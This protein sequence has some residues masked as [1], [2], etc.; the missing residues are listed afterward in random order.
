M[1]IAHRDLKP[2]NILFATKDKDS[3][4]KVIDFGLSKKFRNINQKLQRMN[5]KVGTPI[6]V[7]PEIIAGEYKIYFY[8]SYSF[9]CDEWSLGCILH[10]LLCGNPPFQAKKL[11]MLETK[12]KYSEVDFS[13]SV[14]DHITPEA[15]D[16]IKNLLVK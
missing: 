2:E 7:A 14:F 5:S 9:Q 3:P 10:V 4:I 15:K 16:L 12:I 6:Y 13:F 1:G 8:Y 11:D